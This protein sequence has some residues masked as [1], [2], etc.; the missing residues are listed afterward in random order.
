[1]LARGAAPAGYVGPLWLAAGADVARYAH[2]L[3][4][5]LRRLD[6][7]GARRIVVESPPLGAEWDAV[8]DRLLRAAARDADEAVEGA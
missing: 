5:H 8:R 4:A 3:Y 6:R 7:A 1:V 2:D